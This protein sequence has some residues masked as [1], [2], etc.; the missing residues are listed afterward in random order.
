MDYEKWTRDVRD[1]ATAA[2]EGL[3]VVEGAP[4]S[5]L[6]YEIAC[7]PR[8][9]AWK[10]EVR[11]D[12]SGLSV[13]WTGPVATREDAVQAVRGFAV[14][15]LRGW[16]R[17]WQSLRDSSYR[18]PKGARVL[19]RDVEQEGLFGWL[20]PEPPEAVSDRTPCPQRKEPGNDND[21]RR[22]ILD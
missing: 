20:E 15:C 13:P 3:R 21:T 17:D 10:A 16:L 1:P 7:I 11:S 14:K 12:Y 18:D 8:G 5:R 4:K 22:P 6:S 19:L 9:W 2:T